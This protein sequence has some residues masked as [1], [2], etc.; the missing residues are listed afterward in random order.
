MPANGPVKIIWQQNKE[1]P[2]IFFVCSN[3]SFGNHDCDDC[4][5]HSV[6]S[7]FIDV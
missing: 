2:Q 1:T 4:W 7:G 6:N 3:S 5:C